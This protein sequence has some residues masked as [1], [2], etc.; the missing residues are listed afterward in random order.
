M[1]AKAGLMPKAMWRLAPKMALA[2]ARK[3]FTAPVAETSP[4]FD[5]ET[6]IRDASSELA[7]Q[8]RF[9]AVLEMLHDQLSGRTTTST[10]LRCSEAT[11]LGLYSRLAVQTD[12]DVIDEMLVPFQAWGEERG[13]HADVAALIAR[14]MQIA[15]EAKFDNPFGPDTRTAMNEALAGSRQMLDTCR[16]NGMNR[17]LWHRARFRAAIH[18]CD[19]AGER[20]E[21]FEAYAAFDRGNIQSYLDRVQ[22]LLPHWGGT[23]DEIEEFARQSVDRTQKMWKSTV[24]LQIYHSVSLSEDLLETAVDWNRLLQAFDDS[25]DLFPAVVTINAFIALAARL[26]KPDVVRSLFSELPELR[27]DLWEDEEEPFEVQAWA[28]GKAP[29]P[30][31]GG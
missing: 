28:E 10:G 29:W 26:N 24:Y 7:A 17:E 1:A 5:A 30:Y 25:L 31:A 12:A 19:D 20:Q 22:Q 11:L 2:R 6:Q 18:E 15:A 27:M 21:R 16:K 4:E 13:S 9:D 3:T 14:A 23:M 8:S